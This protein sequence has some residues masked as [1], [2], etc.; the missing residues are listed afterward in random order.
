MR[1]ELEQVCTLRTTVAV[2]CS[3]TVGLS[4]HTSNVLNYQFIIYTPILTCKRIPQSLSS[5]W[6]AVWRS[7]RILELCASSQQYLNDLWKQRSILWPYIIYEFSSFADVKDVKRDFQIMEPMSGYEKKCEHNRVN[8]LLCF[9][10]IDALPYVR[11]RQYL[12]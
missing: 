5:H 11:D 12:Q 4:L 7:I 3:S 1:L 2:P 6:L 10:I 8:T 9:K